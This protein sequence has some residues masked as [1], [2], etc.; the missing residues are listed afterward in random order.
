MT[1]P[2]FHGSRVLLCRVLS[3]TAGIAIVGNDR[4]ASLL[5]CMCGNGC[6]RDNLPS[7][8]HPC[9][10]ISKIST[11]LVPRAWSGSLHARQH[12]GSF[13]SIRSICVVCHGAAK[14]PPSNSLH[15]NSCVPI[16]STPTL[17]QTARVVNT[18]CGCLQSTK[19]PDN[20]KFL[21]H[22]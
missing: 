9:P 6:V 20:C 5:F 13:V 7:L 3:T 16:T 15:A 21:G 10:Q 17:N 18:I 8:Q 11:L 4:F 14:T 19:T 12:D 22:R 2:D 1:L